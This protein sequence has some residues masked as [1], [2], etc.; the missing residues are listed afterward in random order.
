MIEWRYV[1]LGLLLV[2]LFLLFI[3]QIPASTDY[4]GPY[5]Y[6][7][8]YNASAMS[9]FDHP[10]FC[11]YPMNLTRGIINESGVYPNENK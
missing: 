8:G 10:E 6:S 5:A 4:V 7:V 9:C 2:A 1:V 3:Y 11:K